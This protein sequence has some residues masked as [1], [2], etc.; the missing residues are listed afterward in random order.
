MMWFYLSK[1]YSERMFTVRGRGA[2]RRGEGMEMSIMM[3]FLSGFVAV[4]RKAC[5]CCKKH[6]LR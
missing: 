1:W 6:G 3:I 4:D 2:K 5:V